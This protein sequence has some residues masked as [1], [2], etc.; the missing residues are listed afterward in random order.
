MLCSEQS[1]RMK[2][3]EGGCS[4][5]IVFL[6]KQVVIIGVHSLHMILEFVQW[7]GFHGSRVWADRMGVNNDRLHLDTVWLVV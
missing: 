3:R 6:R 7:D 4:P 2:G 1:I 5:H